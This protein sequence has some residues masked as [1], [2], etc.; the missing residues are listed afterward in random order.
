LS[1][2]VWLAGIESACSTKRR[3]AT[4]IYQAAV[5]IPTQETSAGL[6]VFVLFGWQE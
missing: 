6:V 1:H 4:V 3:G 2:I 5:K